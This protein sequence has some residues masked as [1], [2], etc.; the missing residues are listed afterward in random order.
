MIEMLKKLFG[1]PE[2]TKQ[3]SAPKS[4][5][6]EKTSAAAETDQEGIEEFVGYVVRSLVDAPESVS[7]DS[8]E[9][10]SVTTIKISC[11]KPDI[12]KVIGKKGR[13]ISAIRALANGAGG[14]IGQRVNVE[15]E[16]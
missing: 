4:P 7:I 9:K 5:A 15:V 6:P 13:T 14:R 11:E 1:T 12:G 3:D 10:D 16:D 2:E 8:E